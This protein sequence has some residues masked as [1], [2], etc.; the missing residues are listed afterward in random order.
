MVAPLRATSVEAA[1][2]SITC[3][4]SSSIPEPRSMR[5]RVSDGFAAKMKHSARDGAEPLGDATAANRDAK[6][7]SNWKSRA[8]LG[9]VCGPEGG[10][11]VQGASL[12]VPQKLVRCLL[13]YP[14][15]TH[16]V[17]FVF[18]THGHT[19]RVVTLD[20]REAWTD[21]K[22]QQASRATDNGKRR[23]ASV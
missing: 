11:P 1:S 18:D 22:V 2:T 14:T 16:S 10:I 23:S 20:L 19:V 21:I 4:S 9:N 15:A 7:L 3:R 17:D 8:V 13:L 5:A 12:S 6:S